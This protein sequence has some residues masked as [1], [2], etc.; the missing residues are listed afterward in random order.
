VPLTS[1]RRSRFGSLM[2]ASGLLPLLLEFVTIVLLLA[3]A[4]LKDL[5]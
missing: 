1:L 4:R 2:A 5:L 3:A